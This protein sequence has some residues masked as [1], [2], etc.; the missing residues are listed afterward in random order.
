VLTLCDGT[1]STPI[2]Q[3]PLS[4]GIDMVLHSTTKFIA[5]HSDV[6]GGVIVSNE[7]N[8][9]FEEALLSQRTGVGGIPSPF[10]CW[11]TLRGIATLP[12]RVRAQSD[13]AL[14]IARFLTEQTRVQQ[15]LYPGLFHHAGHA[16]ASRQMKMFGAVMS[17]LF[18][19]SKDDA[20]NMTSRLNLFT[21]ATSLGGTHSLIEHRASIEGPKSAT[22]QNLLRLS[23]GLE[24]TF[25]L[26]NDLQNALGS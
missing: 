6:V 8:P 1:L 23:I 5:G 24:N 22:P 21:R 26:M 17:F 2:L 14:Q 15:V 25:D 3:N 12:L 11:L 10:D 19:G 18:D 4:L 13:S 20:L 7:M 16:V 9:L